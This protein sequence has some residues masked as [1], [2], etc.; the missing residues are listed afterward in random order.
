[1]VRGLRIR[2]ATAGVSL[3][4]LCACSSSS[5]GAQGPFGPTHVLGQSLNYPANLLH[6]ARSLYFT[7][8]D[9]SGAYTIDSLGDTGGKAKSL[10]AS[11]ARALGVYKQ[12]LYWD[13]QNGIESMPE[14]GGTP[15]HVAD[16]SSGVDVA[17]VA[18]DASGVY[19]AEAGDEGYG[20]VM[21]FAPGA[22]QPKAL[23]QGT[24][25]EHIALDANF[26]YWV[27]GGVLFKVA[28]TGGTAQTLTVFNSSTGN[29]VLD[30]TSVYWSTL[31]GKILRESKNGG[32]PT[33]L[34]S[35]LDNPRGVGID[36][37]YVYFAQEGAGE[38]ERVPKSGGP[39]QKL[40]VN[41]TDPG[42]LAVAG[43]RVFWANTYSIGSTAIP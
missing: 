5:G 28:K 9:G 15:T 33:V 25:P 11:S 34:V 7:L 30:D 26:V 37:K 43:G 12:K 2:G 32:T 17:D 6:D 23:S 24:S 10:A 39:V 14:A 40:A 18:A 19:W 38:I 8:D 16:P 3:L 22:A 1:M 35:D 36:A 13:S 27:A 29:L 20:S 41:Q 42:A 21:V 31:G 4:V